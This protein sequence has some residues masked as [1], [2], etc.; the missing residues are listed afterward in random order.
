MG[1]SIQQK[2]RNNVIFIM[3]NT[4]LYSGC[5]T[6]VG[7]FCHKEQDYCYMNDGI[8]IGDFRK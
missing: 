5:H 4:K 2:N 1:F 7:T 3:E 8:L 6:E